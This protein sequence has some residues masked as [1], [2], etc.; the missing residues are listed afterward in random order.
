[1]QKLMNLN[2]FNKFNEFNFFLKAFHILAPVKA[3]LF[4][5]SSLLTFVIS[6][7]SKESLDCMFA[8]LVSKETYQPL[9]DCARPRTILYIMKTFCMLISQ[10]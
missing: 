7:F 4:L 1:M 3:K 6:K 2:E 9:Y 8:S 5:K 10:F